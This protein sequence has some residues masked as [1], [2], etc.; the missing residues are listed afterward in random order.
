MSILQFFEYF[1]LI[2]DNSNVNYYKQ[3]KQK[4]ANFFTTN[5]SELSNFSFSSFWGKLLWNQKLLLLIAT[6]WHSC[7]T[8]VRPDAA[9]SYFQFFHRLF[10][11]LIFANKIKIMLLKQSA[12]LFNSCQKKKKYWVYY[13]VS[14]HFKYCTQIKEYWL[15]KNAC[16]NVV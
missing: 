14:E 5:F 16:I 1:Q 8:L 9:L 15:N 2:F 13:Y 3:I 12:V 4:M 7:S 11:E 6:A 10:L